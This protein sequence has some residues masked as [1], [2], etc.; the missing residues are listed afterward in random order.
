MPK[1]KTKIE[2][3]NELQERY[4]DESF[5][6]IEYTKCSDSGRYKC[7]TCNK[8]YSIYK[9]GDLQRKQHLC[10]TCFQH[11]ESIDKSKK[12]AL[13]AI[14]EQF[15]FVDFHRNDDLQKWMMSAQ[16]IKC[17]QVSTKPLIVWSKKTNV[18]SFCGIQS[19]KINTQGFESRFPEYELLEEY[20][21]TDKRILIRHRTCGFIWKTAP[22]NIVNGCGCPK[23]AKKASKGE[24][25]IIDYLQQRQI[26]FI[27]ES[28]FN[29]AGL[30]RY[31][32]FLPYYNLI[33]EYHGIQH[34]EDILFYEER[35]LSK[36][37]QNDKEKKDLALQHGLL[38]LEIP[39]YDFDNIETILDNW[40]NDY[41]QGVGSSEPKERLSQEDKNIV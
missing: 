33:I 11:K 23:C 4:P 10:H 20:K 1:L 37:Q 19:N 29:W 16:C 25:K 13:A 3:I 28:K 17:D 5:E 34:Y 40:F 26:E 24:N 18:C 32:F 31:D 9:M 36:Q 39:Y 14:E 30:K 22:H 27:K 2:F 35:T 15:I 6:I 41:P 7:L 8:E 38:Y 12:E 21:N